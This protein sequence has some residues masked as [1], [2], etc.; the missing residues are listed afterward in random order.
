[1]YIRLPFLFFLLSFVF[2]SFAAA[3]CLSCESWDWTARKDIAALPERLVGAVEIS[4]GG[5]IEIS[6]LIS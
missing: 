6:L 1:L 3:W 4:A 5:E 2:A